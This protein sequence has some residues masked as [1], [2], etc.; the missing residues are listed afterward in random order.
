MDWPHASWHEWVCYTWH[1]KVIRFETRFWQS[2]LD[3]EDPLP[4]DFSSFPNLLLISALPR[5]LQQT[6]LSNSSTSLNPVP[7]TQ[8]PRETFIALSS[9]TR[10]WS[11]LPWK[12][13]I[14]RPVRLGIQPSQ[15]INPFVWGPHL[16]SSKTGNSTLRATTYWSFRV[17]QSTLLWQWHSCARCSSFTKPSTATDH[18]PSEAAAS[19]FLWMLVRDPLQAICSKRFCYTR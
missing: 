4:S 2:S 8:Q 11:H 10:T 5:T 3:P 15:P 9:A 1:Q 17:N 16:T 14:L 19:F 12:G 6:L 7:S 13:P 18:L